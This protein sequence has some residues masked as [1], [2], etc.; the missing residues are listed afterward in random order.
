MAKKQMKPI[1]YMR[2]SIEVMKNSIQESRTDDKVSPKVGAVIVMPNGEYITAYRGELRKGDH[3]EYTAIE[4][5]CADKDLT[6]A[7]IY[8][9][10]EPCAPNS[11]KFPKRGCSKRITNAR[12]KKVY[13]GIEDPDPTV[14]GLGLKHLLDNGVEVE[15][16]PEELQNEIIASNEEFLRQAKDRAKEAK[17]KEDIQFLTEIEKVAPNVE[18]DDL[19]EDLLNQFKLSCKIIGDLHSASVIRS[20]VQLGILAEINGKTVPTGVGLLLFGKNPQ[21]TYTNALIRATVKRG[22]MEDVKTFEGALLKQPE[23]IEKWVAKELTSWISREHA[24]REK[25]YEYPL[26]TIRE[27]IANAILHRDYSIE[28]APIYVEINEDAIVVKSP[29]YPVRPLTL[30]QIKTFSAPSLSRNPKIIYVFDKF[31]LAEQRGL[32]FKTVRS[33]PTHNIPLPKVTFEEPYLIITMPFKY[34]EKKF[35]DEDTGFEKGIDFAKTHELFSKQEY[36]DA[37]SLSVRTAERQL[38]QLTKQNIL[39]KE[40]AG[41]STKYKYNPNR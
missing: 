21:L 17:E 27:I 33:L 2:L 15:M 31:D 29:G 32:G 26:D 3:A 19:D 34:G 9:T 23:Q 5:K 1:D 14:C 11:R 24:K 8:A 39:A 25:I 4:R 40:G 37:L 22:D 16:Y 18:Y 41:P 28:G 36:A 20:F 35:N 30:Q 6:G 7:T 38:Q 10:L 12:I 13:V